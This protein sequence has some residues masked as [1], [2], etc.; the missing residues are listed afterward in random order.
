M[1][2]EVDNTLH[3]ALSMPLHECKRRYDRL[4]KIIKQFDDYWWRNT[5]LEAL[6]CNE[7]GSDINNSPLDKLRFGILILKIS[8]KRDTHLFT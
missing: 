1:I 8:T 7:K 4:M 6:N 5:F 2:L 3:L